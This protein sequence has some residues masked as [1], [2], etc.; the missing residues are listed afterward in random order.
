[1]EIISLIWDHYLYVPLFNLLIWL[2]TNF[3]YYNLGIAVII[4]T[5]MLRLVLLPFTVV[6][7][8]G[9]ILSDNLSKEIKQID[10]DFAA[11]PVQKKIMVRLL[12]KKRKVRPWAKAVSL[13]I[14]ALMLLLL[15]QVFLGGI[16]TAAKLHLLYPSI[17]APDFINTKFLWFDVAKPDMM[18]SAICG[19]Y[20]FM[21]TMIGKYESE[22]KMTKGE[23]LFAVLFPLS[24]FI[25]LFILPSVKSIFILTSLLFSTIISA[26][27]IIIKTA[28]KQAKSQ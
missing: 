23:L 15:Y 24:V 13:A 20:L 21:A 2:Y 25:L 18:I 10:R 7:E 12:L 28:R 16:N 9:K 3:S 5:I 27:S 8:R 14:Q 17:S 6:T 19:A 26:I 1:M 11:D 22:I 4:L